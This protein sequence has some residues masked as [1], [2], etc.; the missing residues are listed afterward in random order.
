MCFEWGALLGW[1][2]MTGALDWAVC[3]PLYI[4]SALYCVAYDTIYAHQDKLDDVN[5]GVKS[6]AL[7]WGNNSK[8]IIASLYATFIGGLTLAGHAMGA[9]PLYYAISC[10]GGA[11]QLAWQVITVDLDSRPDCWQKFSSNGYVAGPIIWAGMAADYVHQ[12][13]SPHEISNSRYSSPSS[14]STITNA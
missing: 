10:L 5:V 2:A 4:G 1:A 11:A 13:S 8:P 3:A 6:T 14:D 12:V 7:A 9:G